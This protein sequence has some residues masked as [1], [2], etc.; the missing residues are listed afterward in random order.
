M[1]DVLDLATVL[2][3]W[4][5]GLA[6]DAGDQGLLG[7]GYSHV[8]HCNLVSKLFSETY[9]EYVK[10]EK[11]NAKLA[12]LGCPESEYMLSVVEVSCCS[13]VKDF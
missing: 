10:S 12:V 3:G 8:S 7:Y 1:L 6:E 5:L 4:Q 9:K 11:A 2:G 13:I